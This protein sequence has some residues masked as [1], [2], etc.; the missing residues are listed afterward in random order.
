M[1]T[2]LRM[3]TLSILVLLV[4]AACSGPGAQTEPT[5][6]SIET[7]DAGLTTATTEVEPTEPPA[8]ATVEPATAEAATTTPSPAPTSTATEE[9][10]TE[11]PIPTEEAI[12][13]SITVFDQ[14]ISDGAVTIQEAALADGGWMV[15]H[16]DVY[17]DPGPVVGFAP[18]EPGVN[19][20]VVVDIDVA[21]ASPAL[22]AMLHEDTGALGNYEFPD[23]DPPVL[24]DGEMVIQPFAVSGLTA[25]TEE[26][27][28]VDLVEVTIQGFSFDPGDVTIPIGTT[29]SWT[30][31]ASGNHTVTADDG[32]FASDTLSNGGVFEFTFNNPGTFAYYCE[33]HGGPGSEGMSAVITVT[34]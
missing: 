22:I 25:A 29:V 33:F 11:T 27:M 4:L 8:S 7:S 21:Q 17:G 2:Y 14:E 10:P 6:E 34:N 28:P 30:N 19:E 31:M 9:P 1:K 16:L 24:I 26:A 12:A 15:I 18:L 13:P 23:A 5:V 3:L 20:D 32:S